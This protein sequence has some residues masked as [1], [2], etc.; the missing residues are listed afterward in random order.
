MS[1]RLKP[2]LV[3]LAIATLLAGCAG[4]S[5]GDTASIPPPVTPVP[6]ADSPQG[7]DS[8]V[9]RP[10][11]KAAGPFAAY[12]GEASG[13]YG[14]T[15]G[16]ERPVLGVAEIV[17]F[18]ADLAL[19]V[20]FDD[21]WEVSGRLSGIELEGIAEHAAGE[22]LRSTATPLTGMVVHFGAATVGEDG[23]FHSTDVS[24][25]TGPTLAVTTASGSWSGNFLARPRAACRGSP[26][27]PHTGILPPSA[28]PK[29]DSSSA[30]LP[31]SR[32]GTDCARC[33]GVSLGWVRPGRSGAL[34]F[35]LCRV[36]PRSRSLWRSRRRAAKRLV[37]RLRR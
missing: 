10:A 22:E 14:I 36:E 35:A 4:G 6:D 27:V 9:G 11:I 37:G 32:K 34:A 5:V 8:P 3:V 2:Y 17:N 24:I 30:G 31:T 28:A 19:I 18:N 1:S 20:T 16:A 25:D 21:T 33:A 7:V 23:T 12:D 26:R 29:G 13:G 15:Y